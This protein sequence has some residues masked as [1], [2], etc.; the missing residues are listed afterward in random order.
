MR[1]LLVAIG[2]LTILP[3][4]ARGA[5]TDE[6]CGGS[7][8]WFPV[9]GL[10]VGAALVG[11]HRALSPLLSQPV[12]AAILLIAWAVLTGAMHLDGFGDLCDG[13][14]GGKTPAARL[15]IMKDPHIGVMA[16][17]A[18]G[19]LLM[20]KFAL[21]G[22]LTTRGVMVRALLLSPCLGRW[23]MVLLATTM[24][25]ARAEGGTGA[26]F[27]RSACVSSLIVATAIALAA[28]WGIGGGRGLVVCVIAVGI[29][30]ILRRVCG[31]LLGGITGDGLGAV[32]ELVEAGVLIGCV[33]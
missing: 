23:S 2:C 9:V 5:V 4:G 28:A 3:F 17:V 25:Y 13:L 30:L 32:G 10:G 15:T 33:V 8:L 22:S 16:V 18:I 12:V 1:R 20:L 11:V 21:L 24:P 6:D 31:R 29:S 7:L 27:V 19:C 14:Y 26:P